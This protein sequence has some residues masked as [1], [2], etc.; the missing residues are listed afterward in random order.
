[1]AQAVE[2]LLNKCKAMSSNPHTIRKRKEKILPI[3]VGKN[4]GPIFANKS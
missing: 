3:P 2:F 4:L 1:M